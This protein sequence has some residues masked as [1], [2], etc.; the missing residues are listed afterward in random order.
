M[1]KSYFVFDF[2]SILVCITH[3]HVTPISVEPEEDK[4]D[5]KN[6]ANLRKEPYLPHRQKMRSVLTRTSNAKRKKYSFFIQNATF[7]WK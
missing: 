7:H 2:I 5:A 3:V 4:A 1:N 6:R